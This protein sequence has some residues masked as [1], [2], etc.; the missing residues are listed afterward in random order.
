[1]EYRGIEF[2]IVQS[3]ERGKW[4]WAAAIAGI[5]E[6]SGLADS[7]EVAAADARRAITWLLSAKKR[8]LEAAFSD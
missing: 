7:K 5:G 3:I 6:R 1:M 4:R 2:T 8:A